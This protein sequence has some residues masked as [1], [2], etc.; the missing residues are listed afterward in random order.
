LW[1]VVEAIGSRMAALLD[2]QM[3]LEGKHT[4]FRGSRQACAL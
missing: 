3:D 1:D 2:G 4:E